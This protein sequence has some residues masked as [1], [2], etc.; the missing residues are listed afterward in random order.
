[1]RAAGA[2]YPLTL[3]ALWIALRYVGEGWWVSTAGLYLPRF[4]FGLPLPVLA[5][6]LWRLRMRRL[7][8]AQ[9]ASVLLVVFSLMGLV[10]P[11]PTSRDPVAPSMRVLSLN[12]D[13]GRA[14]PATIVDAVTRYAPDVVLLQETGGNDQ[15]AAALGARYPTVDSSGQF[16]LATRFALLRKIEPDKLLY[17]GILHHPRFVEYLL[18]TNLGPVTFYS[19]HPASPREGLQSLRGEGLRREIRSGRLIEGSRAHLLEANA[20]LRTLQVETFARAAMQEAGP[21]VIAGDTNLPELSPLLRRSLGGFDDAFTSA[22]W[23][24]GYTFPS[25]RWLPWMRIDRILARGGLRFTH[26]E[27]GRPV[28]SDHHFILADLQR[29]SP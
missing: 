25:N 29:R 10:M 6:A 17:G 28:V 19:V 12:V 21:V 7:L 15:L 4:V 20:G 3:V 11:W 18:A 9:T 27:I 24:F 14:G 5:L 26:F 2:A 22:G 23:G 8:V 13:S 1:M 16:V